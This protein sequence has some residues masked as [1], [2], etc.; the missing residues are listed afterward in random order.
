MV[1]FNNDRLTQFLSGNFHADKSFTRDDGLRL[2]D[3]IIKEVTGHQMN[4][5]AVIERFYD[6]EEDKIDLA[7]VTC[8][9][10]HLMHLDQPVACEAVKPFLPWQADKELTIKAQTPIT[11][12]IE[13]C[14]ECQDDINKIIGLD[15]EQKQLVRLGELYT[16][17]DSK[18]NSSCIATRK[19][20]PEIARLN[21]EAAT[22]ETLKHVC[23]CPS[24]RR[25][26]NDTRRDILDNL[27]PSRRLWGDLQH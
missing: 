10:F 3:S 5:R 8:L 12:H 16:H 26:L 21:F 25:I 18:D 17:S 23:I 7:V 27:E 9:V 19:V 14:P 6:P 22:A 20:M 13:N 15:L 4:F 1:N 11:V 24:C 2:L